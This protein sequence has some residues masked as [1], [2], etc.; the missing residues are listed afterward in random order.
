MRPLC[1]GLH[2][3]ASDRHGLFWVKRTK[4]KVD[5]L[6]A[7]Q[8]HPSTAKVRAWPISPKDRVRSRRLWR[9]LSHRRASLTRVSRGLSRNGCGGLDGPTNG[10]HLP[11]LKSRGGFLTL[12]AIRA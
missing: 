12:H 8:T 9:G 4:E 6:C 5:R 11:W 1:S 2:V 10:T 3:L 7:K